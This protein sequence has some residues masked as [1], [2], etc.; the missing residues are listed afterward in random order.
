LVRV[1]ATKRIDRSAF[2]DMQW[3]EAFPLWTRSFLDAFSAHA[4][5][6]RLLATE[7]V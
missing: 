5:A 6:I 1:H 2:D 7:P 4:T 3:D